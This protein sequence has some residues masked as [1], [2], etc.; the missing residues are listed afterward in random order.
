MFLESIEK[1]TLPPSLCQGLITLIPK[2]NRDPLLIEN[3]RPISLL[4]TDYKII[5]LVLAKRLKFILNNI[6]DECQSGFIHQRHISNNIRLIFDLLDYSDLISTDSFILFLDYYKAFDCLEHEFML[7]SL[8]RMGF[9]NFFCKCIK[10]LYCNGNSS[11]R[12]NN[13]TSP[14]FSLKRGVR[15]GCPIS[16]YLFLIATQFLNLHIKESPVKGISIAGT[17]LIISQLADDTALFLRDISQIPIA[18]TS[19]QSFSNAS[20]LLLNINKCELLPIKKCASSSICNIPIKDS[21]TYLGIKIIKDTKLRCQM[22]FSPV[23]SQ[24]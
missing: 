8:H 11:I 17:E 22:N 23:P 5:A 24:Q 10:M 21:V 2:P 1:T 15:Q 3:W 20:G 19:L 16:P 4:N 7:Q 14:R 9:G 12:L 13:G 6:I 18:L